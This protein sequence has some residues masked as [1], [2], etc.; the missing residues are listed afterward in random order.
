[1]FFFFGVLKSLGSGERRERGG[2]G[3]KETVRG[4]DSWIVYMLEPLSDTL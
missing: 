2:G 3:G 1:V 4:A